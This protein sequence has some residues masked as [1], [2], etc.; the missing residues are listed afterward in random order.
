MGSSKKVFRVHAGW[1]VAS[2]A[3]VQTRWNL[4]NVK[5]ISNTV[6]QLKRPWFARSHNPISGSGLV[7]KPHPARWRFVDFLM[8]AFAQIFLSSERIAMPHP[9]FG[10]HLAKPMS[11]MSILASLNSAGLVDIVM[12]D[13]TEIPLLKEL[14]I[15][16]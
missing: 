6:G 9:S 12:S 8:K 16:Q 14:S 15:C 11:R 7:S 1:R 10:V 4:T 13:V 3:N 2:V 5:F